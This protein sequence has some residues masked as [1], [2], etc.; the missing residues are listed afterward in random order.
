MHNI[1]GEDNTSDMYKRAISE[2][3]IAHCNIE[4]ALITDL[5]LSP[6]GLDKEYAESL[7]IETPAIRLGVL[8]DAKV[9]TTDPK[10]KEQIIRDCTNRFIL[11]DGNHRLYSKRYVYN[12]KKINVDITVYDDIYEARLAAYKFNT[13]HGK[14]L[15]DREVARGV[16]ETMK[17]LKMKNREIT[18][19]DVGSYLDITP[20]Q[21]RLYQY[22]FKVEKELGVEIAKTKADLLHPFMHQGQMD[23]LREFWEKNK[24]NTVREL[25]GARR[26]FLETGE[27]I[28]FKTYSIEKILEE[29]KKEKEIKYAEENKIQEVKV[30]NK[31]ELSGKAIE[32][33]KDDEGDLLSGFMKDTG[34]VGSGGSKFSGELDE[35]DKKDLH[36]RIASSE[37]I[38][39]SKIQLEK[40]AL[41]LL[42]D[43]QDEI[44]DKCEKMDS[45]SALITQD[46]EDLEKMKS[47]KGELEVYFFNITTGINKMKGILN[48]LN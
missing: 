40:L 24:G 20:R 12:Q 37:I 41:N 35:E 26:H 38:N 28:N 29:E 5:N 23:E 4:C 34:L 2:N 27:I 18:F 19:N 14:P 1:I 30:E 16:L 15:T 33:K 36:N 22:W 9:L 10:T 42:E 47:K 25:T 43:L 3:G 45:I 8:R 11:L 31:V 6:R 13:N 32:E 7:P 39:K 44:I 48:K 46:T 21:V 17:Y